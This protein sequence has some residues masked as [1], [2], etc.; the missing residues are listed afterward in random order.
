MNI[1]IMSVFVL[2]AHFCCRLFVWFAWDVSS[3]VLL[4]R[5][6]MHLAAPLLSMDVL[7]LVGM[8]VIGSFL[9]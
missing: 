3:V 1:I 2:Y 7:A 6:R 5:V 9:R 4:N 8:F